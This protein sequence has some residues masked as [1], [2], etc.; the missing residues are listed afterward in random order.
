MTRMSIISSLRMATMSMLTIWTAE[1][2]V[3]VNFTGTDLFVF[4][5]S[6]IDP[7]DFYQNVV[8]S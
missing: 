4:D 2:R 6:N 5:L 7:V 8:H 3:R 1:M